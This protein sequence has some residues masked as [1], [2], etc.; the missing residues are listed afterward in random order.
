MSGR[1]RVRR[2]YVMEGMYVS[3]NTA[4][5]SFQFHLFGKES[6]KLN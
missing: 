6:R 3:T 1:G 5:D 2:E 4:L